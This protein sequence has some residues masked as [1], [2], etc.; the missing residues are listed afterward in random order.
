MPLTASLCN[1]EDV[2]HDQALT[3]DQH[4][5]ELTY[6]SNVAVHCEAPCC[7]TLYT[8]LYYD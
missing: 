2:F 7:I 8:A 1:A 5:K 3:F 6:C 4:V